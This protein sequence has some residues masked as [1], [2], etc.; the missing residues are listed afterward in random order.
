[1][2]NSVLRLL[3]VALVVVGEAFCQTSGSASDEVAQY[4][5]TEMARQHIPGVAL[6]VTGVEDP[7]SN[8]H[9]E[10]ESLHLAEFENVCV[11]EATF[12]GL[13][14]ATGRG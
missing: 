5:K 11:A 4:V 9:S 10:N 8:A 7:E 3:M 6:L 1:M 13:F 2:K 12:L 14:G